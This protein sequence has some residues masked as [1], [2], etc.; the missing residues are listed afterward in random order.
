MVC[1][2]RPVM[3]TLTF[4]CAQAFGTNRQPHARCSTCFLS[5]C[6]VHVQGVVCGALCCSAFR[7][8]AALAVCRRG[9]VGSGHS[10]EQ[11]SNGV[12]KR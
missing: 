12:R 4:S 6:G 3:S 11:G 5:G 8:F 1:A 10:I 7:T 9:G 2:L